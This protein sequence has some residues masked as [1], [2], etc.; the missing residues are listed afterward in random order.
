MEGD[1]ITF[2]TEDATGALWIGSLFEGMNRYDPVK[3]KVAHYGY[4][5]KGNKVVYSK[6]TLTGFN[7][8]GPYRA[9]SSKE[10]LFWVM[11]M[12]GDLFNVNSFKTTIP[13]YSIKQRES[14]SLY[15]EPKGNIL[16]V[17]TDDGLLR[18]D[19]TTQNEKLWVHNPKDDN[20]I[21][22]NTIYGMRI[23]DQGKFWLG[24]AGG[25]LDKFD[26][27]TG[28]FV[29]YKH[30][31]NKPGSISNNQINYLYI[32][33][34]K[35]LWAATD[36]GISKMDHITDQFNYYTHNS[37]DSTSLIDD[38]VLC[39]TEDKD[40]SI[41]AGTEIGVSRLDTKSGRFRRYLANSSI[42]SICVD[43][44]GIVWAG[45][46]YALY[47]FEKTKD[48]FLL[49]ADQNSEVG[50]SG[51]LG[52]LEDDNKNLW[53]GTSGYI[54]RISADRKEVRK[55]SEEQGVRPNQMGWCD[56]FKGKD[57]KLFLGDFN[58]FYAFYPNQLKVYNTPSLLN[59][60]NFKLGDKEIRPNQVVY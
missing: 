42:K 9:I 14:N 16:W 31:D 47:Y 48:Q 35:N 56:N 7:G 19:L 27:L 50:I 11:T 1:Q 6:D 58:G 44:K 57:G 30:D 34:N 8:N 43:S 15:C 41:W 40:H 60:S 33:F 55:Y 3:K 54:V 5:V 51:V 36:S 49:Y 37:K 20:S 52:I 17:A 23:D 21:S 22:N 25:G 32:D 29:H 39:I 4:I 13:Y 26:P 53:V 18:R 46:T 59:F 2:I 28:K 24:T 45:G 12:E 38:E 10:G